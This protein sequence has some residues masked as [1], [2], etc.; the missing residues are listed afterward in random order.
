M[1][2]VAAAAAV[3]AAADI[4]IWSPRTLTGCPLSARFERVGSNANV[5][6]GLEIHM[7]SRTLLLGLLLLAGRLGGS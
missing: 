7:F 4:L 2:V 6:F 5:A 1:D 3:V